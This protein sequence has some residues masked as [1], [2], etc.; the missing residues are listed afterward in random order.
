MA[1]SSHGTLLQLSDGGDPE[2]FSTVAEV[3]DI[4][5][6]G[7]LVKVETFRGDGN[8][9]P[10]VVPDEIEPGE[11]T[12]DLNYT[13]EAAQSRLRDAHLGQTRLSLRLVFPTIP[14]TSASFRGYVTGFLFTAPV[15]GVLR[16]SISVTLA[17][18]LAF[19]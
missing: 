5:D 14:V 2:T 6:V 8:G 9:F 15:E 13:G 12:F 19:T 1:V 11:I 10:A 17:S 4:D 16:A 3:L 18:A 7:S